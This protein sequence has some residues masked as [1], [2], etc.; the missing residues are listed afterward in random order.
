L[1]LEFG[2]SHRSGLV[3][4]KA[5]EATISITKRSK[6]PPNLSP[7][8]RER[9]VEFI[10]GT[11]DVGGIQDCLGKRVPATIKRKQMPRKVEQAIQVLQEFMGNGEQVREHWN[12]LLQLL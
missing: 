9:V 2:I 3:R 11:M 6:R 8:S 4:Y 12:R 1:V 7:E 10:N 5:S